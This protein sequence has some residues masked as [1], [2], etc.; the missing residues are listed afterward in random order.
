MATTLWLW[1]R[2]RVS[3]PVASPGWIVPLNGKEDG[4]GVADGTGG[5]TAVL[6]APAKVLVLFQTHDGTLAIVHRAGLPVLPVGV[7]D[8]SPVEPVPLPRL[9]APTHADPHLLQA[10]I[11]GLE[12]FFGDL[13]LELGLGE[14]DQLHGLIFAVLQGFSPAVC[15][16]SDFYDLWRQDATPEIC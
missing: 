1:I 14:A 4:L 15:N 10:V 16:F 2:L 12:D 3:L 8:R 11:V 6:V 5:L 9:G 13:S 7:I